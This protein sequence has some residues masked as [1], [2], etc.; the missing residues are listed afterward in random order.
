MAQS[1]TDL[2]Q[3]IRNLTQPST[4]TRMIQNPEEIPRTYLSRGN[5]TPTI[6]I[7]GMLGRT[8]PL[9]T[10]HNFSYLAIRSYLKSQRELFPASTLCY[11]TAGVDPTPLSNQ[12]DYLVFHS[13]MYSRQVN[14][15]QWN[16]EIQQ[17]MTWTCNIHFTTA[18]IG[19]RQLEEPTRDWKAFILSA[20]PLPADQRFSILP[21]DNRSGTDSRGPTVFLKT[22]GDLA[23]QFYLAAES[24]NPTINVHVSRSLAVDST[25]RTATNIVRITATRYESDVNYALADPFTVSV[26]SAMDHMNWNFLSALVTHW[27][28]TSDSLTYVLP[29]SANQNPVAVD[30]QDSF[31]SMI[32]ECNKLPE[33]ERQLWLIIGDPPTINKIARTRAEDTAQE[34]G[35]EVALA[36]EDRA[37]ACA[38]EAFKAWKRTLDVVRG[39][40]KARH[41]A[42]DRR[43]DAL[44]T[45]IRTER[46]RNDAE[47]AESGVKASVEGAQWAE[48]DANFWADM[49]STY[50]DGAVEFMQLAPTAAEIAALPAL[51]GDIGQLEP[52]TAPVSSVAEP[53]TLLE[54]IAGHAAE[55]DMAVVVEAE[56][57]EEDEEVVEV[58]EEE[59]GVESDEDEDEDEGKDQAAT[60]TPAELL[61]AGDSV[62]NDGRRNHQREGRYYC[63][64]CGAYLRTLGEARTLRHFQ[65]CNIHYYQLVLARP[66]AK[67]GGGG[68]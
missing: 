22:R 47:V 15:R 65:K 48:T 28:G 50:A 60:P 37:K 49:A 56:Q 10:E 62:G 2:T 54:T 1:A 45:D 40:N 19:Y 63:P 27:L 58:G 14:Q 7:I 16:I 9:P 12:N 11:W 43:S 35:A 5:A 31:Q 25:D 53:G 32:N 23:R 20:E 67:K 44:D 3:P 64:I 21:S 57:V 26:A 4:D 18:G 61:A 66:A 34:T 17:P 6:N 24:E 42:L 33:G 36:P 29:Q 46:W 59:V 39:T 55:E 38:S 41:R 68:R 13:Q 8:F 30:S 52:A 51:G